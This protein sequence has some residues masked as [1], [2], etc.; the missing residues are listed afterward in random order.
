MKPGGDAD[1]LPT[2]LAAYEREPEALPVEVVFGADPS[3]MLREGQADAALL[4]APPD[5]LGAWI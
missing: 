3:C 4:Y 1:L 2:I 5:E